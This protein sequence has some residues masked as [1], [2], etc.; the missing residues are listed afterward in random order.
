MKAFPK[1]EQK[2]L[3]VTI[4]EDGTLMYLKTREHDIFAEWGSRHEACVPC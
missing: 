1:T 4:D 3:T 2:V